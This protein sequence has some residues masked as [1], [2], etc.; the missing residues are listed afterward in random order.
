MIDLLLGSSV[1]VAAMMG[2]A[3]GQDVFDELRWKHRIVLIFADELNQPAS[4]QL[5]DLET[6]QAEIDDRDLV[7]ITVAG[8]S[9]ES[10]TGL[11]HLPTAKD[12]RTRFAVK[13]NTPFMVLLLGK[14]GHEKLRENNPVS[15]DSLFALIDSMPMRQQ[16]RREQD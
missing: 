8:N 10:H 14:D 13:R 9:V 3:A 11:Q 4:H 1:L 15:A 7:I 5:H 16:E 12:L 6:R 2:S